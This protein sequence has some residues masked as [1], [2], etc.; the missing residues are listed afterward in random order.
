MWKSLLLLFALSFCAFA[1]QSGDSMMYLSLARDFIFANVWEQSDVH[2]YLYPQTDGQ[3]IWHHEYLTAILFYA[4]HALAGFPA[5]ILLKILVLGILFWTVIRA[6][7]AENKNPLWIALWIFAVLAGSFRFIERASMFSDLFTVLT[8]SWLLTEKHLSKSLLVRLIL[9]FALWIQLHPGFILGFVFIFLWLA[10]HLLHTPGFRRRRLL[11]LSAV[12]L[13]MLLNPSLHEGLLYPLRFAFHE[14]QT[15]RQHNFEW[16]PAYHPAFRFTPEMLAF[17]MLS[18]LTAFFFIYRQAWRSL[19]AVFALAAFLFTLQAV[20]FVPFAA[21]TMVLCVKP[22]TR[23]YSLSLE[24]QSLQISLAVLLG[25]VA[26]KNLTMG[27]QSSSGRRLASWGLDPKFFPE[28]TLEVLRQVRGGQQIYNSHDF[29]AYLIWKGITPIFHHGFVTDMKFY[30]DEVIGSLQSRKQFLDLA[31][32]YD[33]KILLVDRF[34]G[35]R[36]AYQILAPLPG[37]KIVAEDE[38]S[39]LIMYLP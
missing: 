22:W 10:W 35:Y 5:L 4:A 16:F 31:A 14:T 37:W 1:I 7:P 39:Y 38:A 2:K 34:G 18:A 13:V 24:R 17:W 29:G 32:K 3:L 27:Y 23:F 20:R 25:V 6:E 26:V 36:E 33:W 15:L 19:N 28:K 30:R 21:M 9:L 12:P 8:A 11:W